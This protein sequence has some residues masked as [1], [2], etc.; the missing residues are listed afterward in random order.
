MSEHT[1]LVPVEQVE[2]AILLVRGH[3]VILDSD[4]AHFYEVDTKALKR[5][6]RRNQDRFPPDF[7]FELSVEEYQ[8]LR[9]QFGT[10][11]R[12]QHAKY[13]PYAF[14]QEGVAM[15]SSV[16]RSQRAAQVN[17]AIM[18]AFVR[19][20]Q[21][22]TLHKDLAAKLG[23]LEHKI[24]HHDEGIRT[25]FEAIR[26]LMAPPEPPRKQIGFQIKERRA[27]YRV[28]KNSRHRG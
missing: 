25:L 7:M 14:T 26:Q 6:V 15:L 27:S 3:K 28:G 8:S 11:K 2:R 23:E 16:L 12:G 9:S 21:T 5:A 13:P 10:L 24:E 22:L 20:R 1:R 4:L 19:L 18:R 17:V